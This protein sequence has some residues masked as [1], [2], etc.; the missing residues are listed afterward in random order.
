MI[1]PLLAA[2]LLV[3]SL[4]GAPAHARRLP[5]DPQNRLHLGLSYNDRASMGAFG[6]LDSRLTRVVSVDVGGFVSPFAM[7]DSVVPDSDDAKDFVFLRH[8]LYVSPGLRLPHRQGEKVQWDLLL[9]PGFAAIFTQDVHP[10]NN[11]SPNERFRTHADPA[12]FAGGEF[13]IRS[14][15]IGLRTGARAYLFRQ[16]SSF[17]GD[18]IVLVRPQIYVEGVYQF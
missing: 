1:R 12:L 16:F 5:M 11:L 2:A 10:D 14:G 3:L 17:E 15:D 7:Q 9:R 8:G 6:G 13:L 18:D 4:V